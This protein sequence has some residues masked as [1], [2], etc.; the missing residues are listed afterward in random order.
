MMYVNLVHLG[1]LCLARTDDM[2]HWLLRKMLVGR[3]VACMHSM[4]Y[5]PVELLFVGSQA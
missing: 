3:V 1:V 5:L 2:L 4:P